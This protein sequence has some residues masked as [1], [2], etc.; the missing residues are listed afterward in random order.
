MRIRDNGAGIDPAILNREYKGTLGL[1]GMKERAKL[2]GE[3]LALW[4]Q[5]DVGTEVD[6]NIPAASVYAKSSSPR[7]SL[8][9]RFW[10]S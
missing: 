5:V 7:W 8:A 1:R 2:V 10:N 3:T 9:S 6:L 4:S